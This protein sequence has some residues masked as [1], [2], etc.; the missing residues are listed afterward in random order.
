MIVAL[1]WLGFISA[2]E[3]SV[4]N[5][6]EKLSSSSYKVSSRMFM[7]RQISL[8]PGLKVIFLSSAT[9]SASGSTAKEIYLY[10]NE[11]HMSQGGNNSGA[12][13]G[14]RCKVYCL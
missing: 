5:R 10:Q 12:I 6:A 2:E 3:S 11:D 8:S 9:K 13:I 1:R 14:Q 7:S 4:F